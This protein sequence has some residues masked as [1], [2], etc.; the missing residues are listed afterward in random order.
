MFNN[1]SFSKI[2]F[3]FFILILRTFQQNLKRHVLFFVYI[4]VI[5]NARLS[6]IKWYVIFE[7]IVVA[8]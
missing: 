3:L 2:N 8:E 4:D 7:N 5:F 1:D 6:L